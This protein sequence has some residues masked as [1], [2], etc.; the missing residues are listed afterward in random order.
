MA[1]G[2]IK[3]IAFGFRS[4]VA[5]RLDLVFCEYVYQR[6]SSPSVPPPSAAPHFRCPVWLLDTNTLCLPKPVFAT[7]QCWPL[8][9]HSEI[10]FALSSPILLKIP[11]EWLIWDVRK[12][13]IWF[14]KTFKGWYAIWAPF[15]QGICICKKHNPSKTSGDGDRSSNTQS[16]YWAIIITHFIPSQITASGVDI[17][18]V[19]DIWASCFDYYSIVLISNISV[20]SIHLS[21][22]I[23]KDS[24]LEPFLYG[25]SFYLEF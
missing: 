23:L 15:S 16:I 22:L 14:T 3:H 10:T 8:F 6:L 5:L 25:D 13:V 20:G 11:P 1:F 24:C 2:A 9:P 19:I 21:V 12:K 18:T 17:H 4:N 7:H